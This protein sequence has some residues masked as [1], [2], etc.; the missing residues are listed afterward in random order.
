MRLTV[1]LWDLFLYV[2]AAFFYCERV[3]RDEG[4]SSSRLRLLAFATLVCSPSIIF[5]D[6]GHFQFNTIAL[7]LVLWATNALYY[8]RRYAASALYVG[9]LL[10]K[11]TTL[12]YAPA[13]FL[14]LL[15]EAVWPEECTEK[16]FTAKELV[17]ILK[18]EQTSAATSPVVV[19]RTKTSTRTP[20]K[21]M[22]PTLT[23]EKNA[24]SSVNEPQV[25][26]GRETVAGGAP[27]EHDFSN[28]NNANNDT[29]NANDEV[30]DSSM[31]PNYKKTSGAG[32]TSGGF[33][34]RGPTTISGGAFLGANSPTRAQQL[35]I[36]FPSNL[37]MLARKMESDSSSKTP[38]GTTTTNKTPRR[39]QPSVSPKRGQSSSSAGLDNTTPRQSREAFLSRSTFHEQENRER[40]KQTTTT[41]SSSRHGTPQHPN[42]GLSGGRASSSCT[43]SAEKEQLDVPEVNIVN[44]NTRGDKNNKGKATKQKREVEAKKSSPPSLRPDRP[45]SAPRLAKARDFSAVKVSQWGASSLK[46]TSKQPPQ[47]HEDVVAHSS[48]T[49]MLLDVLV[50]ARPVH[51]RLLGEHNKSAQGK[52]QGGRAMNSFKKFFLRVALLGVVVIVTF[53]AI[54]FPFRRQLLQVKSR[55]FPFGRG[56]FEDFVSNFWVLVSPVLK[57]RD[58]TRDESSIYASSSSSSNEAGAGSLLGEMFTPSAE[59]AAREL[60]RQAQLRATL[61]SMRPGDAFKA[62]RDELEATSD[63]IYLAGGRGGSSSGWFGGGKSSYTVSESLLEY[64]AVGKS[65]AYKGPA[66]LATAWISAVDY[67]LAFTFLTGSIGIALFLRG[68]EVTGKL[69]MR[70]MLMSKGQ[71]VFLCAMA[72]TLGGAFCSSA[73]AFKRPTHREF[74]KALLGSSLSFFLFSWQVHEKAILLP[75][76]PVLLQ[77]PL[78]IAQCSDHVHGAPHSSTSMPTSP[79]NKNSAAKFY[80]TDPASTTSMQH[81]SLITKNSNL[82]LNMVHKNGNKCQRLAEFLLGEKLVTA[83]QQLMDNGSSRLLLWRNLGFLAV[84]HVSLLPL[85]VK[86]KNVTAHVHLGAACVALILLYSMADTEFVALKRRL[87]IQARARKDVNYNNVEVETEQGEQGGSPSRQTSSP[88]STS[89]KIM[90]V[91]RLL[92][93]GMIFPVALLVSA[94]HVVVAVDTNAAHDQGTSAT[95]S[96][97]TLAR[98]L[99]PKRYPHLFSYLNAAVCASFFLLVFVQNVTVRG[100]LASD[101]M[102]R[103]NPYF[104][105][106]V[107]GLTSS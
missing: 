45:P 91:W 36:P 103:R 102:T 73:G 82:Q 107:G 55:V 83:M 20:S 40:S 56:L 98:Q 67:F 52:T 14:F 26:A 18:G 39:S 57:L 6:H 104:A 106:T 88:K 24:S 80:N 49:F 66:L 86:D 76:L 2:S 62:W 46:M 92:L 68:G 101:I 30:D 79:L 58:V 3:L 23:S 85:A 72:L 81:I 1:L 19:G 94:L 22:T 50:P 8:R 37:K 61:D 71:V 90:N 95:S 44:E 87:L 53:A 21:K 74:L 27:M 41:T 16:Q 35:S 59:T 96:L 10:Y 38:R 12:Y 63:R 93:L 25:D 42:G 11:Q 15:G 43:P 69:A 64:T 5:I 78:L 13:F 29:M 70:M 31:M 9:A 33:T 99:L 4:I 60:Q 51:S 84:A 100:M 28:Q 89:S 48:T 77:L 47:T 97:S 54:M 32:Q 65:F 17:S 105:R 34:P 75:L 7:G